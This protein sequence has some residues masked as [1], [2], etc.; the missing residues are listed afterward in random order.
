MSWCSVL[1]ESQTIFRITS[2]ALPMGA[3]ALLVGSA[4]DRSSPRIVYEEAIHKTL[5][6]V[7]AVLSHRHCELPRADGAASVACRHDPHAQCERATRP[8]VRGCRSKR[9]FVAGLENGSVEVVDLKTGKWLRTMQGF[10]KPQGILFVP[11][12]D[13]VFV[14]SGDDGMVRVFSAKLCLRSAASTSHR[15]QSGRKRGCW[16][17]KTRP[18]PVSARTTS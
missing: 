2:V 14:A 7:G 4:A 12:L 13:K 17:E 8:P 1:T 11:R 15:G 18:H 5:G 6:D 9:L 16:Q 10:Q 3:S